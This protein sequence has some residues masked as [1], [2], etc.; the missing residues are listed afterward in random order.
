MTFLEL[1]EGPL[2]YAAAAV[3]VVGVL[4]RFVG[5]IA[6]GRKPDLSIARSSAGAGAVRAVF[7][8]FIPH[9]GF[10]TKTGFHVA[11][12]YLFH[13]ALF[14]LLVFA[15]PHVVFISDRI[16]GLP[17]GAAAWGELPRWAFIVT[18]E[19]AFFGIILLWIRRVTDPVM[20]MIS[21]V[22]DHA[23][24]VLTFIVMLTGCF[25]LGES[26]EALRALHMFMVDAWLVYFPFS[27]LTHAFTFVLSRGYTG[28]LFGRRGVTP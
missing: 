6:F 27:R 5:I 21:D 24:T 11:A 26:S 20:R 13:V 19:V 10:L 1:T 28:A 18:A 22:G 23:G 9:G 3:F 16:L 8:H 14:V 4:W 17:A 12:G 25:A 2:W 15:A 7:L